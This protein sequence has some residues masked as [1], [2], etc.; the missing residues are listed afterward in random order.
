MTEDQL[1]RRLSEAGYGDEAINK[2]VAN[3]SDNKA[4]LEMWQERE[5]HWDNVDSFYLTVKAAS[6]DNVVSLQE[7]QDLCFKLPQWQQQLQA[8]RQY[9]KEYREVDS[10][11]VDNP[12]NGLLTLENLTE[13]GL[14]ELLTIQASCPQ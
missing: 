8:S 10:E 11:T 5:E 4:K 6:E 1:R 2:S 9:L 7:Y 13:D 12:G 14:E 3:L